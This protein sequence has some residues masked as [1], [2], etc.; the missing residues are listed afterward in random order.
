MRD[1]H[2][3]SL[4]AGLHTAQEQVRRLI[5]RYPG[6][7]PTYTENGRWRTT[8]TTL[9]HASPMKRLPHPSPRR[10]CCSWLPCWEPAAI[11]TPTMRAASCPVSAV[12]S[13]WQARRGLGGHRQARDL[14]RQEQSGRERKRDVGRL[15]FR[16]GASPQDIWRRRQTCH[17][18]TVRPAIT[19]DAL[20][21]PWCPWRASAPLSAAS[22]ASPPAAARA[23]PR[24]DRARRS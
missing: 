16:R 1:D 10:A 5:C 18:R 13:F 6:Q 8:G 2:L 11:V 22:P 21:R 7:F 20:A 15:L 24:R 9:R 17:D 4:E 14:S 12:R 19:R 3:G 23:S